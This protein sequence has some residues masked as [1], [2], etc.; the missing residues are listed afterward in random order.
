MTHGFSAQLSSVVPGAIARLHF[1]E[2]AIK[3]V[4]DREIDAYRHGLAH[5]RITVIEA[6]TPVRDG[7]LLT[8]P[9]FPEVPEC[10][11]WFEFNADFARSRDVILWGIAQTPV[12]DEVE[13]YTG[14]P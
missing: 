4:L 2:R 11:V 3:Y 10:M 14:D 7:L 6:E 13:D 8:E 9:G 1:L 5:P 12:L